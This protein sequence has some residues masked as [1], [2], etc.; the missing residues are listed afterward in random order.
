MQDEISQQ[1]YRINTNYR[2]SS[3]QPASRRL[4]PSLTEVG[5]E[6]TPNYFQSEA[7]QTG[8]LQVEH[9]FFWSKGVIP[10]KSWISLE[11]DS[12]KA[13]TYGPTRAD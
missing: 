5:V 13:N 11:P 4:D 7:P 1:K 2:H 3:T 9:S 6:M 10:V 8:I 12:P